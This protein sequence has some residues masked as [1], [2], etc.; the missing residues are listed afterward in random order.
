MAIPTV[1]QAIEEAAFHLGDIKKRRFTMPDL[2]AAV[3]LAWREMIDEMVLCQ[4][5]HVELKTLYVLPVGK[6]TLT[7]L[8]AAITNF[9]S[10]IR[11]EERPAGSDKNTAFFPVDYTE[12]MPLPWSP[13]DRLVYYSWR[14]GTFEFSEATKPIEIRFTYLASGELPTSGTL[15]ID[16]CLTVVGKLAAA[17]VGPTKGLEKIPDRLRREVY[18]APNHMQALIQPSLRMQQERRVQPAAYSVGS[19]RRRPRG[20]HPIFGP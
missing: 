13:T 4:D 2:Q 18:V 12:I 1:E 9:G 15:G 10:L 5:S 19:N 3:G 20:H 7:P 14:N 17:L 8:E 16:N 11:L 6:L